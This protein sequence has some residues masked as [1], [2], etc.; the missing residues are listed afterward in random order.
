MQ[1]FS[2]LICLNLF[3]SYQRFDTVREQPSTTN[4][5]AHPP[6]PPP[7]PPPAAAL[8]PPS[9]IERV[10][11]PG[12]F[13]VA[14]EETT[15][16]HILHDMDEPPRT[17]TPRAPTPP[18]AIIPVPT[19]PPVQQPP[20]PTEAPV[21]VAEEPEEAY[22]GLEVEPLEEP[23]PEPVRAITP[24]PPPEVPVPRPAVV[25]APPPPAP[26]PHPEHDALMERYADALAEIAR[27]QHELSAAQIAA[28]QQP[29]GVRRRTTTRVVSEDGETVN[30]AASDDGTAVDTFTGPPQVDGVPINVVAVIAFAVFLA[31]YLFF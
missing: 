21:V 11:S 24:A 2:L 15:T 7:P 3:P 30:D 23:A 25:P 14:Q 4:G 31:T 5:F 13:I 27:L 9:P 1:Y 18:P 22:E 20:L 19:P 17:R 6:L 28:A 16:T 8:S 29:V 26:L 12:D 10:G